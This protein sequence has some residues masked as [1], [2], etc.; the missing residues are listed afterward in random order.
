MKY[1][2]NK[3]VK[4][5]AEI[6]VLRDGS[7]RD[8][9]EW[10]AHCGN[11]RMPRVAQCT[12]GCLYGMLRLTAESPRPALIPGTVERRAA[13]LPERVFSAGIRIAPWGVA[14]GV[15]FASACLWGG[16]LRERNL[17]NPAPSSLRCDCAGGG[18]RAGELEQRGSGCAVGGFSN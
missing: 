9:A 12:T 7:C 13:A 15:L 17:P 6:S 2:E 10:E 5:A 11:V 16:S 1:D 3:A 4:N 8:R 18:F 14:A